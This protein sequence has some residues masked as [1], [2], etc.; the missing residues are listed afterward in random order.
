VGIVALAKPGDT[1]RAGDPILELHY[2]DRPRLAEAL[3]LATRAI[4]ISDAPPVAQPLVRA[5]VL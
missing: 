2:R 1:L 5:E 3:P 4:A